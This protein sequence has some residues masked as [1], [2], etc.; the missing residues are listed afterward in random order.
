MPKWIALGAAICCTA[1]ALFLPWA[2]YGDTDVSLYRF[3]AWYVYVAA[4]L[5]MHGC[6]PLR[7][8]IGRIA[9]AVASLTAA[10]T[11]VLLLVNPGWAD[12][13]FGGAD[14]PV[15]AVAAGSSAGALLALA[16]VLTNAAALA[17][18]PRTA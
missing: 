13:P 6:V 11:A 3:P 8:T 17:L 7:S 4:A 5:A 15:P 12:F 18:P 14:S 16:G 10:T 1:L 2:R 9:G